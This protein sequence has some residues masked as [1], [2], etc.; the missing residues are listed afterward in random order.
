MEPDS[1]IKFLSYLTMSL[2]ELDQLA[3]SYFMCFNLF[4]ENLHLQ[5]TYL[6]P[7]T[8]GLILNV[9]LS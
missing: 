5:G 2:K 8:N 4:N 1:Q 6:L 9:Y 3:T 7:G